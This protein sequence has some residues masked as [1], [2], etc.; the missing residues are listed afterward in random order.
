MIQALVSRHQ[1]RQQPVQKPRQ[2][3]HA[4]VAFG[5]GDTFDKNAAVEGIKSAI[6]AYPDFPK[7]GIL[8]R[9]ITPVLRDPKLLND[10]IEY[11]YQRLKD[12]K[13]EY[14]AGIES[15]GFMLGAPLAHKLGAGFIPIRKAGKLPGAV[16]K[17]KYDLEYGTDAVEIQADAFKPGAKVVLIDDLLATGGTAAA[18]VKLLGKLKAD[19]KSVFFMVELDALQGRTK[20]QAEAPAGT[21]LHSMLHY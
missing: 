11:F 7:P 13:V 3:P 2:A 18:A 21:E 15:R 9:D 19:L 5:N 17:Q 16:E 4:P 8:F 1:V 14:V 6:R 20:L 10:T 12:Q